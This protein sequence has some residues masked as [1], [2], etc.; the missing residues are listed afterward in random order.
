[1]PLDHRSLGRLSAQH[2]GIVDLGQLRSVGATHHQI[3]HLV[4]SGRFERVAVGVFRSTEHPRTPVQD[5]LVACRVTGGIASYS[6]AGWLWG[7]RGVRRP[8][9]PHVTIGERRRVAPGRFVLH[10]SSHLGLE[11][12][13]TRSDGIVITSLSRTVFDLAAVVKARRTE[14]IIEQLLDEQRCSMA[15]LTAVGEALAARG[16]AGS[17]IYRQLLDSRPQGRRPV[18][19]ELELRLARALVDRGL[20][21]PER[22]SP[23][24]LRGGQIVHPDLSWPAIRFAIEVNHATWHGRAEQ[25]RYDAWRYRQLRLVGWH[26]EE[27]SD[28]DI[29]GRLA[30]TCS[31]LVSLYRRVSSSSP[32][33]GAA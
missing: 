26:V 17:G 9:I 13:V 24:Q 8:S 28:H 31:D 12:L 25:S 6:S 1:M 18:G 16:R 27:V 3:A 5:I 19:S 32:D 22:Q 4:S 29:D 10:R 14:S 2:H 7:M 20:P 33:I 23:V 30:E 11:H 21:A 15:D